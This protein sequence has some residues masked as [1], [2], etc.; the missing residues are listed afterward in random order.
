MDR[1]DFSDMALFVC[2]ALA[3]GF[4][5]GTWVGTYDT[6]SEIRAQAIQL[7]YAHYEP[8]GGYWQW[9]TNSINLE[10]K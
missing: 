5:I 8:I 3:I 9:K 2:I 10:K 1:Y 7:G 6:R 4:M